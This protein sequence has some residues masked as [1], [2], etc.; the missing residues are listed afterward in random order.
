MA[1]EEARH[2]RAG[3]HGV[4]LGQDHAGGRFGVQ[5]LEQRALL[6][7]VG[8]GRIAGAGRMP[9]YFSAI[10]TSVSPSSSGA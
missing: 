2:R 7:V 8:L 10:I 4:A 3:A 9:W 1:E 6:G 5:Q